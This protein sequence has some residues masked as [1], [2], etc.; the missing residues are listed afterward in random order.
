MG[1]VRDNSIK[2]RYFYKEGVKI[3]KKILTLLA[4]RQM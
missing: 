3:G 1:K 4:I 2:N